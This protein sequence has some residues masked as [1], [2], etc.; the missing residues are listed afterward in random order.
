MNHERSGGLIVPRSGTILRGQLLDIKTKFFTSFSKRL[1]QG[2]ILFIFVLFRQLY[3]KTVAFSGIRT[4]IIIVECVHTNHLTTVLPTKSLSLLLTVNENK[5][6]L[7]N[8]RFFFLFIKLSGQNDFPRFDQSKWFDPRRA[9]IATSPN[10]EKLFRK[11]FW[12]TNS[13]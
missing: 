8:K 1:T 5:R 4:Q 6:I 7:Y 2:L 11:R 13:K 9:A 3:K 10:N 12:T